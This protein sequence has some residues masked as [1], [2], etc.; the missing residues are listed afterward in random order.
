MTGG[1]PYVHPSAASV[2]MRSE[3]RAGE[4][5]VDPGL[6]TML[7]HADEPSVDAYP[8]HAIAPDLNLSTTYRTPHPSSRLA[9]LPEKDFD[10]Q[11]PPAHIYSRYS[12]ETRNRVEQVLS[13]LL[14]G[15]ALAYASGLNA[16]YAVAIH[17]QPTTIAIRRGYFGCHESFHVYAKTKGNVKFIDLDDEFPQDGSQLLVWLETPLNPSGEAR[18]IAHYAKRAHQVGGKIAIDATF[19]PPPLQNPFVQG[20]D[21]VMHSG[22]KYMGGHSDVLVGVVAVQ[23]KAEAA[24]LWHDRT[25][26]GSTPGNLESYLLLRS[27]RT[28]TVRV[29]QQSETASKLA[30]W[31]WTLSP[32]NQAAAKH[33]L[34][35]EDD[36]K[37]RSAGIVGWVSHGSLQPRG[38]EEQDAGSHKKPEGVN[39]DPRSQMPG[40][41]APTF[42]IRLDGPRHKGGE[43]AAWL[44]HQTRYWIPATSLGGVESLIEH[45]IAAE[46]TEDPGTVRLSVGL[47][48]FEDLQADLRFAL[49][50]VLSLEKEGKLKWEPAVSSEAQEI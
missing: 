2:G 13:K 11:S 47:E 26:I 48:D 38:P 14:G 15:H 40:G 45:R 49:L 16:A 42:A 29:R 5:G 32:R 18:D 27:L 37:I 33:E 30:S 43:R 28:L 22:T 50:K 6:A 3:H 35:N 10:F 36:A 41:F 9:T 7:L 20:A 23:D 34:S 39:F 12:L 1:T 4:L 31:L 46:P 21:L 44:G 24:K 8:N 17:Y 19:A 25:Y